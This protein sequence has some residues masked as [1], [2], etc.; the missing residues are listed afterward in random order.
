[1]NPLVAAPWRIPPATL[2]ARR[3]RLS[4]AV[5]GEP[6]LL[7]GHSVL[8]RNYLAN[9]LPYRQDSTFLYFLGVEEPGC[10]ALV[11][12]GGRT[13]LFVPASDPSDA[14]WHGDLVPMEAWAEV[15]GADAVA[16]RDALQPAPRHALPLADPVANAEAARLSLR[17]LDPRDAAGTGSRALLDAVVE[18]RLCRDFDELQAIRRALAVT[19]EA[20]AAGMAATRPGASENHV[21]AVVEA[22]FAAHGM[23]TSYPSIVTV[24]GEILHGHAR[25]LPCEDGALMLVDAGAEDPSGYA[26][27]VTRTWPVSGRFSPRQR[28]V[29]EAVL[30]AQADAIARVRPGVRWRD[31]HRAAA[32]ILA[33]ALRD[34]GLL[35]GDLDG[36]VERGAHAVL[37][38]HGLG[39][40]M[41]LDVHD[42]ELLGDAALY[43]GG[44]T[45][46]PQF[47]LRWLRFD[48]D[49]LP[50]MVVTV[51]PGLYFSPAILRDPGLRETLGDSVDWARCESWLPFGGIRIEDDVLVTADG[52]EV[53]S[54][55]IPKSVAEVESAVGTGS[56][57]VG[58]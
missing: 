34:W 24:R 46:S 13:T 26:S 8:P 25:G 31:V 7:L 15:A 53:L 9:V 12:A 27:D 45:R 52:C 41:G 5:S 56:S 38:P 32:R 58:P 11:E 51:E 20:H 48:R 19:R 23:G 35:R 40:L 22:V 44:R 18:Q 54:A 17:P 30:A 4:A 28:D 10:A 3:A 50:G 33:Q 36:L 6:L 49:L 14:F 57:V 21:H 47:G 29:Y 37:F 43:E 42:M 2:R 16:P 39:H 1:V 55:A